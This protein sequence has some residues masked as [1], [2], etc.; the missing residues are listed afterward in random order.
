M[1][2][3]P[4][5]DIARDLFY[6]KDGALYWTKIKENNR[7]A[8]RKGYDVPLGYI[9]DQNY[10]CTNLC[11]NG[12]SRSHKVHRLI[13]WL[14][15]GEWPEVVDHIDGNTLNNDISNLRA[16]TPRTNAQNRRLQRNN[17]TGYIGVK[18][19]GKHFT[20]AVGD[21]GSGKYH[22]VNG[23]KTAKDAALFRDLMAYYVYGKFAT[24]NF[25]GKKKIRI[26]GELI[27]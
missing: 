25:L 10:V 5:D 2:T 3:S 24:F 23:F 20:A 9:N 22:R 15:T 19:A 6:Y 7:R 12:V 27:A 1:I 17:T 21:G 16:A 26:D 8:G 18:R 11:I 4:P 14:H 13:Y